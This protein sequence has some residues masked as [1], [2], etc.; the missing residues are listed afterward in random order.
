MCC[1]LVLMLPLWLVA[2]EIIAFKSVQNNKYVRAGIGKG[3]KLATSRGGVGGWQT[4]RLIE[5]GNNKV[6]LLSMQNGKYVRAGVGKGSEL[7]AVST[8]IGG[9][10]KF[11]YINRANNTFALRNV[12]NRKYVRAGVGKGSLLA[13]VSK[14]IDS[15]E[16]FKKVRSNWQPDFVHSHKPHGNIKPVSGRTPLVTILVD[17]PDFPISSHAQDSISGR[18]GYTK[19]YFERML[20]GAKPSAR[21]WFLENSYNKFSI[22]N[23][24]IVGWVRDN[25][26]FGTINNPAPNSYRAKNE[27][28]V[29]R[30][31]AVRLADRE[32]NF[33]RFDKN[34]DGVVSSDEL[35]LL[36]VYSQEKHS[37]NVGALVRPINAIQTNDGVR[38]ADSRRASTF[39]ASIEIYLHAAMSAYIHELAHAALNVKDVYSKVTGTN[40]SGQ[41]GE[42]SIMDC[43]NAY[44]HLDPWSKIHLGWLR[45]KV[46]MNPGWYNVRNIEQN[47]DA[48]IVYQPNH[49]TKEYYIVENR[50]GVGNYDG[51]FSA[52]IRSAEAGKPR[53]ETRS[54]GLRDQGLAIWHVNENA[55]SRSGDT[56]PNGL[57]VVS[58]DGSS[59][60]NS[61]KALWDASEAGANYEFSSRSNPA[62]ARWDDNS[63]NTVRIRTSSSAG[64]RM[65]VW[66]GY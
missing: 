30:T 52:G 50:W 64:E 27:F 11:E 44:R 3:T 35:I 15:W 28:R 36:V 38:I 10:E 7:A 66:M 18:N 13:A 32:I 6:A 47:P 1:L 8:R 29:A 65:R 16:T 58:V 24:G 41:A 53:N 40:C 60:V 4:F 17:Y 37:V 22:S 57:R 49:G 43:G 45:P 25:R 21:D 34:R 48:Y 14:R 46:V 51:G 2:D 56:R 63:A 61:R 55:I 12:Q 31:N 62:R 42:F 5:L 33:A 54:R 9:W 20:F 26:A 19:A 23:G 39:G 59:P